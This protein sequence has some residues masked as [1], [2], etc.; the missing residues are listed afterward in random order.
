MLDLY[1]EEFN[2]EATT[3][4]YGDA[5]RTTAIAIFHSMPDTKEQQII[6]NRLHYHYCVPH[7]GHTWMVLG[8]CGMVMTDGIT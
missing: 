3:L 6:M 1:R 4:V 8:P 2:E 7:L 5:E